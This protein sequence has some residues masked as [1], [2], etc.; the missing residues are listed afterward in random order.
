[1]SVLRNQEFDMVLFYFEKGNT[2]LQTL[3]QFCKKHVGLSRDH[4]VRIV[5]RLVDEEYIQSSVDGHY[6]F[7]GYGIRFL[8]VND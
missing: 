7:K 5:S 6:K 4:V 2:C 1:M 3:I 8:C